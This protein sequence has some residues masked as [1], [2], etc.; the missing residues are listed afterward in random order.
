MARLSATDAMFAYADT[1]T[2][3]MNVGTLQIVRLPKGYKGDYLADL[4]A[5]V[6]ECLGFLPRLK[7]KL[8]VDTLGLPSW[9]M[10]DEVDLDYHVRRTRVRGGDLNALYRK[11]G[12]LQ[13]IP[14]DRDRPLFMFYLIEGMED[15]SLIVFQKLHH[16]LADGKTAVAMMHLSSDEGLA[17]ARAEGFEFEP[18]VSA[19]G[20]LR[21]AAGGILED[22]SRSL[23]S[24]PGVLGASRRLLSGDGLSLMRRLSGRPVTRFNKPL[25]GKRKFA[26]RDWPM[27]DFNRVRKAAGLTFNDMSLAMLG[28]ALRAY[29]D[30]VD[31]LPEKSLICNVPVALPVS[32][33]Q[34]G[35]AVFSLWIQ[36]GTQIDGALE[37]A[38]FIREDANSGKQFLQQVLEK[39]AKGQG[40][41]LPSLMMRMVALPLSSSAMAQLN[42]PPGNVAL[43]NVPG[44]HQPI[45]VAGARV[46]ALFGVPMLLQGQGIGVTVSSYAGKV[47]VGVLSCQSAMPDPEQ[48]LEYMNDEF[49]ALEK[50]T[51]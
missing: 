34:S 31:E 18:P 7:S 3:P 19:G 20:F 4:K 47:V 13:H 21:R 43:S 26:F 17:K 45:H 42:P 29:L 44:P 37:R 2:T 6:G 38:E 39:A 10:F 40:V 24:L 46:E 12:R 27:A 1:T 41:Q 48:L 22:V 35:N 36:L 50:A 49:R 11:V 9:Q 8:V 5:F 51:S 15:G 30:E 23:K 28:G 16:A 32:G 25:S 14:L 33:A